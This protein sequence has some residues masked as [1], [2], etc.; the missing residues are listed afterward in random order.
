[1]PVLRGRRTF[2]RMRVRVRRAAERA[3]GL[4]RG[5]P[6]SNDTLLW[7]RRAEG[8]GREEKWQNTDSKSERVERKEGGQDVL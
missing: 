1:M 4:L 6:S 7:R 5:Q 3:Q 8:N 2:G